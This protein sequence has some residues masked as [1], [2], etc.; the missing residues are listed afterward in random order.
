MEPFLKTD[1]CTI[2]NKDC[3][4]AMKHIPTESVDLIV[5]SPPYNINKEYETD[6][7]IHDYIKWSKSWIDAST[8]LLKPDGTFWLNVGYTT[9]YPNAKCMP[10]NYLLW[11]KI[12]MHFMQEVVWHYKAGVA[13]KKYFSPRNEKLLWYVKDYKKYKFNLD[14]IR[15]PHD[16][17]KCTCGTRN[18]KKRCNPNGKNPTNV[19]SITRVTAGKNRSSKERTPHPAQFPEKLIEKCILASTNEGDTILDPF[20]GSGTTAVVAL[21]HKRKVIGIELNKNYCKIIKKRLNLD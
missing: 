7:S 9:S 13:C 20:M 12:P 2:Y 8:S 19:W 14:A 17:T 10:L 3:V 6:L 15:E 18:G 4:E 5:T 16:Q 11:D 1:M 21:K